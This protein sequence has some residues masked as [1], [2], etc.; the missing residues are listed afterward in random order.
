MRMSAST[1]TVTGQRDSQ[2]GY[3]NEER[4]LP[5]PPA[6]T[7]VAT[8]DYLRLATSGDF[9]MATDS[10]AGH[11]GP[12]PDGGGPFSGV[13]EHVAQQAQGGGVDQ[14]G[15]D[16]HSGTCCDQLP[17]TSRDR[18]AKRG[19]HKGGHSSLQN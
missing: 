3:R 11:R 4:G 19:D 10:E 8:S 16:T 17:R 1:A 7:S 9:L 14:S 12:H 15:G 13:G 6:G 2:G 5:W 18:G